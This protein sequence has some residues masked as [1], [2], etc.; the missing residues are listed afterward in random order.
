MV[1]VREPTNPYFARSIVNR[2]ANYSAVG[3]STE[4][5]ERSG[6]GGGNHNLANPRVIE[7]TGIT[8]NDCSREKGFDPALHAPRRLSPAR[9]RGRKRRK[10]TRSNA[11]DRLNFSRSL[12]SAI[13]AE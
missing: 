4:P 9:I 13:A 10:R 6:G 12:A 3:T 8:G 2:V 1:L 5:R 11:H 7:R